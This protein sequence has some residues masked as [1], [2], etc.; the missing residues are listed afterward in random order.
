M[1]VV[2]MDSHIEENKINVWG[3]NSQ[4]P[5]ASFQDHLVDSVL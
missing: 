2:F 3:A 1:G 5:P 4:S